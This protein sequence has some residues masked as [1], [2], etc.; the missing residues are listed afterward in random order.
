[1]FR[2][3]LAIICGGVCY[4]VLS[5]IPVV[6]ELMSISMSILFTFAMAFYLSSK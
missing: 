1:M 2:L 6:N 3:L 5:H 4:F